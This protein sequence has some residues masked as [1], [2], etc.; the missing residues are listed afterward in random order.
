[1]IVE[2]SER[3]QKVEGDQKLKDL[4]ETPS[5]IVSLRASANDK[6]IVTEDDGLKDKKPMSTENKKEDTKNVSPEV[7]FTPGN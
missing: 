3:V 5:Y 4:T 6:T 7:F 2:L 1:M